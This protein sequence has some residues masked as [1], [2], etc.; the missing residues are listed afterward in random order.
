M[1]PA[2]IG[3]NATVGAGSVITK[4]V[5]DGEL[6]IARGKQRTVPGWERPTK[7]TKP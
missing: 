2:E 7:M 6:A 5:G 3:N 1:A 4:A